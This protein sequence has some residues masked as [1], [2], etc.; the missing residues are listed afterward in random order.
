MK[1][2][3]EK[4][5]FALD[6]PD[7]EK[8]VSLA[9]ELR[10]HV[11]HFKI[12]LELFLRCGPVIIDEIAAMGRVF[13]DLKIHDIPATVGS[14]VASIPE[15]MVSLFTVHAS[16]SAEALRQAVAG[17]GQMKI[18]GVTVLTSLSQKDL[19]ED[20]Y[21]APLPQ[22]AIARALRAKECGCAGAVCSVHEAADIRKACGSD[23]LIITP[24]IR[25]A[26]E[27][28]GQQDQKRVATPADAIR[29]G[30]DMIV[31]GRAIRDSANPA[32]AA[33]RILDEIEGL[34]A[35]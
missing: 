15:G 33:Q 35:G 31:V 9:D 8:A 21:T 22:L 16:N 34:R 3:K 32:S 4:L 5:I 18:I 20:G 25:P 27:G 14:A 26:W 23:F 28:L 10:G 11:G 13:L 7:L 12:G 2:P 30:A 19:E 6:V 24:G 1:D 17:A 29:A